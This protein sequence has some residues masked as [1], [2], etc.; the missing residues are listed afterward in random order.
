MSSQTAS[1]A[2][3]TTRIAN[4]LIECNFSAKRVVTQL[5]CWHDA[6]HNRI[7]AYRISGFEVQVS[8]ENG[9]SE[10]S[11]YVTLLGRPNDY[12]LVRANTHQYLWFQRNLEG[13]YSETPITPYW[14]PIY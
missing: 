6:T 10:L 12:I 8:D 7:Y 5:F 2:L 14:D 4:F 11:L 3:L 9:Q 13:K 1:L